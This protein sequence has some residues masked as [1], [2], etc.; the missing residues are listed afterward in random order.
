MQV[1]VVDDSER[2]GREC[3]AQ[4]RLDLGRRDA[5]R[6]SG[7]TPAAGTVPGGLGASSSVR[8]REM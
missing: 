6:E 8:K 1:A 5:H 7:P 3:G 4:R 2:L